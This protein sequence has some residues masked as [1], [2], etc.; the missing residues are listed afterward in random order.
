MSIVSDVAYA[1]SQE[2][3]Q[4]TTEAVASKLTTARPYPLSDMNDSTERSN[5]TERLLRM[6]DPAKLGY[7]TLLTNAGQ[8]FATF[9]IQGKVSSTAS[10]LT[11]TQNIIPKYCG[12]KGED[13]CSIAVDSMGD[14][15]SYGPE[16]GG[17][18]GIFFFTTGGV[19]IEWNGPFHYT[20]A[21]QIMTSAPVVTLSAEAKPSSNMG[22]LPN[23]SQIKD[24]LNLGVTYNLAPQL[25]AGGEFNYSDVSAIGRYG[26]GYYGGNG[27]QINPMTD[28]RQWWET[29]IN[30]HEQKADFFRTGTNATWNWLGGYLTNTAGNIAK[31]AYHD[32]PYWVRYKNYESDGRDRYFG[33]AFLNYKI[34]SLIN[35]LGRVSKDDYSQIIET[36]YDVGSAGTPGYT[37]TLS[38]YDETNYDFL[39]N[40]DK[41][42]T[43]HLNLKALVGTNV[44]QDNY[45]STFMSTN[46][47]LVV[48]GFFALANSVNTPTAPSET[49]D[50][51]EVDGIFAGATLSW[52]DMITLD[53]TIRR[54][55][56]STLPVA[57]S[58]FYYPSVSANWV[59]SKLLTDATWLTYGKLRANYAAVGGDAPYFSLV[60]TYNAGTAFN[61]QTIFNSATT[62]NNPNLVPEMNHTYEIGA[63]L[64]FLQS[65]LG[66]DV[67]YYHAREINQILPIIVS[68]ASGYGQFFVNGGTVQNAGVELTVNLTPVKTR[69]FSWD[70][71]INWT[72]NNNKIISL[73]NNEPSFIIA[74]YQNAVQLVAEKGK[75]YGELRGSDY[76]YTNGKIRDSVG[77]PE[78]ASNAL[79]DI[80]N[81]NPLWYGGINNTF[82]YKSFSLSFLIDVKKGGDVY[83][84]DMDYG[85]SAG[86]IPHTAGH[87]KSGGATRAPLASGGGYLFP[88]VDVSGKTNTTLVDASDINQGLFP[89]IS[90]NQEAAKTYVYDAGYVKLREAAL[91]YSLPAATTNKLHFVKGLDVSLT[92]RNLWIIHKNLPYADPEQGVPSSGSYGANASQGFQSGSYPVF[93]TFGFNIKARF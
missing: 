24:L 38:T 20:D 1:D 19:L 31:P 85:A 87:N 22:Y 52:K 25:T 28:F 33:N 64:S 7:V 69:N 51:R 17:Q 12:N 15:G 40:L 9:T 35:I 59:F 71:N 3:A 57:H 50:R 92:G 83:S 90:D 2:D 60:N 41:N 14:D 16:E 30:L 10:Q 82:H 81:I 6:N 58:T 88:G 4:A 77:Y 72:K 44:R 48:P 67:T 39:A 29:G 43:S 11:N 61:G 27:T 78:K 55:K 13:I 66:F 75:S 45:S 49:V 47:G 65:R 70:M 79:S 63:E 93:R 80:G 26:Y 68:A 76:I 73:Y 23:S 5:L 18:N 34:G 36:R 56:S 86:L 84:L 62:N 8:I 37:K 74:K 42:L 21:P 32:N 46:G 53:G 89:F 54:D 91:T